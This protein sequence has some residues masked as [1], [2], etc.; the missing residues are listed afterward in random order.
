M[1]TGGFSL[2]YLILFIVFFTYISHLLAKKKGL[3]AVFWGVMGGLF[4]PLAVLVLLLKKS[5]RSEANK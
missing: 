3:D 1:F 2:A 5:S 4:G